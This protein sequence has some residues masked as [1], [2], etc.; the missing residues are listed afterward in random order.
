MDRDFG[1]DPFRKMER[2][3]VAR[4]LGMPLPTNGGGGIEEPVAADSSD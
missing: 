4:K 2:I 3:K 1:D